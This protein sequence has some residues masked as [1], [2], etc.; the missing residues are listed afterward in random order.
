MQRFRIR[1][2]TACSLTLQCGSLT[3]PR[4][5]G[6]GRAM[7]RGSLQPSCPSHPRRGC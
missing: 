7:R 5:C 1:H 6:P 3:T 4:C 2:H